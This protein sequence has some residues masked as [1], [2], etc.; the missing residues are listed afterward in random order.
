[1]RGYSF[2]NRVVPSNVGRGGCVFVVFREQGHPSRH[3]ISA[4]E[5]HIYV[6]DVCEGRSDVSMDAFPMTKVKIRMHA[7]E[8]HGLAFDLGEQCCRSFRNG[9]EYLEVRRG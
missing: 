4:A 2:L 7:W 9:E 3:R 8:E 5:R 1:M 6:C